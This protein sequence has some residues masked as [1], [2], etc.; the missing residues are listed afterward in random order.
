M[1]KP[2]FMN[3]LKKHN[4]GNDNVLSL[5]N[6]LELAINIS[7]LTKIQKVKIRLRLILIQANLI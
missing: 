2:T 7:N 3:N 1:T 6:E 5:V 4:F